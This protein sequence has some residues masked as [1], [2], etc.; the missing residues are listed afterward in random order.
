MNL[1]KWADGFDN[2]DAPEEPYNIYKR[3]EEATILER[4]ASGARVQDLT[5]IEKRYQKLDIPEIMAYL[6]FWIYNEYMRSGRFGDVVK[7]LE[8]N[9]ESDMEGEM[10]ALSMALNVM[11]TT[12]RLATDYA[13]LSHEE[14]DKLSNLSEDRVAQYAK[15]ASIA[16]KPIAARLLAVLSKLV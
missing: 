11:H 14:L 12:G 5:K 13:G 3:L 1:R 15:K 16:F 10:P 7:D 6:Y 8:S 2:E 4:I 9:H